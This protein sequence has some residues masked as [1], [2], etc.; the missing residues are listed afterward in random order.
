MKDLAQIVFFFMKVYH[1]MLM[2]YDLCHIKPGDMA[3]GGDL[4]LEKN[5]Q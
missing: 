5:E 3:G 4:N 2:I 1:S